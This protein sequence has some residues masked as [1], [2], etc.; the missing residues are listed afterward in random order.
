MPQKPAWRKLKISEYSSAG[1]F[2]R[3][4]ENYCVSACSKFLHGS[5]HIWEYRAGDETSALLL[6]GHRSLNPVFMGNSCLPLPRSFSRFQ[7]LANIHSA[8]GLKE[9]LEILEPGMKE[10]G[11][12]FT[13]S[14]DYDLMALD[15]E[16]LSARSGPPGL[17]FRRPTEEDREE[18]FQLQS[19]YEREE[20]LPPGGNFNSENCNK[21][22][23]KFLNS[24]QILVACLV[25]KIAGKINTNAVSFTRYQIGGVYVRPEFRG[26]GIAVEM[27]AV[28]LKQ[29]MAE[30]RGITLFV[31]KRNIA[32]KNVYK[33]LG[34]TVLADYRICYY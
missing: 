18:L 20:V 13:E 29:L 8:A 31:K 26:L 23:T 21:Q 6:Y 9:D 22:I 32:A 25:G 16:P 4:H 27:S 14:I 10:S 17:T 34:F 3:K 30:G 11:Y 12:N 24:G 33:R 2:L 5:S 1:S 19:A 28:F 7:Q 15:K